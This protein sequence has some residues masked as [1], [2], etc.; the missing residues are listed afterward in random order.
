MRALF[1]FRLVSAFIR[2]V[3]NRR[4]PVR[5]LDFRRVRRFRNP[6]DVVQ[7]KMVVDCV[8]FFMCRKA[9]E[10][11]RY[12]KRQSVSSICLSVVSSKSSK[13]SSSKSRREIISKIKKEDST[14][15][16]RFETLFLPPLDTPSRSFL[17]PIP[18]KRRRRRLKAVVS[19]VR[20]NKASHPVVASFSFFF[21]FVVVFAKKSRLVFRL[22]CWFRD[23]F[24]RVDWS[25]SSF[26][27]SAVIQCLSTFW[28]SGRRRER[29]VSSSRFQKER[30][31]S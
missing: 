10:V 13:S 15:K 7:L 8:V 3:F 28:R 20:K 21:F 9:R 26:F 2:V 11:F 18:S 12:T 14:S 4:F 25:S 22:S 30:P 31:S 1:K 27:E 19:I 17:D 16:T 6:E 24:G 29:K 5:F 23:R